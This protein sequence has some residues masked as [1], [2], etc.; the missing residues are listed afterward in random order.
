MNADVGEPLGVNCPGATQG[1]VSDAEISG[2][3]HVF[4]LA[5]DRGRV[6]SPEGELTSPLFLVRVVAPPSRGVPTRG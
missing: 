5:W 1:R 6:R 4:V 3:G 2:V